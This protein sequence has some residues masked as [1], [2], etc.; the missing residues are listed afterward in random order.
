MLSKTEVV[1]RHLLHAAEQGVRRQASLTA[2]AAELG[3][4]VSTVHKALTLPVEIGAV[5]VNPSGGVRAIDP[6]RVAVLWAGRRRLDRDIV[7]AFTS[8]KS[9]S[10]VERALAFDGVVLGG[11]GAVVARLGRNHISDYNTVIA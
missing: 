1:W 11:H 6:Y 4:G 3:L 7:H 2:L 8:S 5:L 10:S 9:A